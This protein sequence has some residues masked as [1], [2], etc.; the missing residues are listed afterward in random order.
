MEKVRKH[1][2]EVMIDHSIEHYELLRV[3]EHLLIY[4]R[5]HDNWNQTLA[6]L[7]ALRDQF[8][9]EDVSRIAELAETSKQELDK[10]QVRFVDVLNA[11]KNTRTPILGFILFLPLALPA[12]VFHFPLW[13]LVLKLTKKIVVDP[14]F[15]STF[16]LILSFVL[17]PLAWLIAGVIASFFFSISHV[18]LGLLGLIISGIFAL[19]TVDFWNDIQSKR[20]GKQFITSSPDAYGHWTEVV[21][22]LEQILA[23]K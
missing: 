7:A 13:K 23:A 5:G 9:R 3:A 16:K 10:S 14:V 19:K 20:K 6:D 4:D 2:S 15:I 21:T 1:L 8:K 17:F 22:T 12:I 18:L 11:H